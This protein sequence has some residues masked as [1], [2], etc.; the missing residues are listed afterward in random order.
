MRGEV[1]ASRALALAT[2]GR[3]EEAVELGTEAVTMTRGVETRVLWPSVRAVAALKSRDSSLIDRAEELV[4]VS[5]EAGAVDILVCAYRSNSE[6]L[7]TLLGTPGCA[8]R[9]VYALSRAGDN[10]IAE[11]M[12]LQVAGSLDPRS[13]LSIRERE[14][15][16]L[17]CAGLTNREIGHRLFITEGTVKVH[18]HN[19]FDKLGI[20]SRTALAMNAIQQRY[21]QAAPATDSG[22]RESA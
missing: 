5:F 10:D 16:D 2:L 8:E 11:A 18:V 6:L 4:N 1:L 21:G 22:H 3:V 12:G 7:A 20:R 19:M 13:T 17:V 14:V 9:T 15:Y